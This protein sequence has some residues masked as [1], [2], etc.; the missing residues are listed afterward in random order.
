MADIPTG[1]THRL[2]VYAI[3]GNALSDPSLVGDEASS[4]AAAAMNA[5]LSDVVDLLEAGSR[6]VITHGNGPQVGEML[7]M[8]EALYDRRRQDGQ[9]APPP[10]GLDHWVAA[11]QGT[12]G[13]EIATHLDFVLRERG[14]HEQVATLLTRVE[15]NPKDH[16]FSHPT[17][18]IGPLIDDIDAVPDDWEIVVTAAGPRRVVA[19]P[20]PLSIV[21]DDAIAALLGAGAVVLCSGGGGIP[22]VKHGDGHRGVDAVIDKDRVSALLATSLAADTL[23]ISTAIDSIRLDFGKESERA[24]RKLDINEA[25]NHM[26]SGQFPSG[27]MG[28]KVSAMLSAKSARP[29]MQ[30]VLCQPGDAF[31]ALRGEAGTEIT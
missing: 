22:V 31:A 1:A 3:G 8:E 10:V 16:A 17:K 27:N 15:V 9:P 2:A 25:V 12:L 20:V 11:T 19:S 14:R 4:A 5:V 21:D 23:V 28:P 13:H 29:Q 26:E 7:L 24:L 6:V 18:P 30:V